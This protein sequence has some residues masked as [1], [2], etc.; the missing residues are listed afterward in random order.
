MPSKPDIATCRI[1]QVSRPVATLE[2]STFNEIRVKLLKTKQISTWLSLKSPKR[3][4]PHRRQSESDP[5]PYQLTHSRDRHVRSDSLVISNELHKS[6][7]HT[8]LQMVTLRARKLNCS[9]ES[10]REFQLERFD[11]LFSLAVQKAFLGTFISSVPC[12]KLLIADVM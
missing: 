2:Q 11:C 7:Y 9:K 8:R 4:F 1:L 12:R 6:C 10:E 5:T 3:L